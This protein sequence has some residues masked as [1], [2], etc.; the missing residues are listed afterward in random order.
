MSYMNEH[1]S[2]YNVIIFE[3]VK[4]IDSQINQSVREIMMHK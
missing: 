4:E 2:Q 1:S 3:L